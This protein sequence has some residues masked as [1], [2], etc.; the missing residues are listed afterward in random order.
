MAR[1][2]PMPCRCPRGKMPHAQTGSL[3]DSL[4][5]GDPAAAANVAAAIATWALEAPG[6]LNEALVGKLG[7][8]TVLNDPVGALHRVCAKTRQEDR[9]V[10]G[11][12]FHLWVITHLSCDEAGAVALAAFDT[13]PED[14][15]VDP[16]IHGTMLEYPSR[17]LLLV[18]L[19]HGQ[20]LCET[21]IVCAVDDKA[22]LVT[23]WLAW[24][25]WIA[26]G[27]CRVVRVV[28]ARHETVLSEIVE[29][30]LVPAYAVNQ[31]LFAEIAQPMPTMNRVLPFSC[32][33]TPEGAAVAVGT[34]IFGWR[35]RSFIL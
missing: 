34:L 15:T 19:R 22:F 26:V 7:G 12:A 9:V 16:R 3:R 32:S 33:D 5:H 25:G 13:Q 24:N 28:L 17:E 21:P 2:Q 29:L 11:F 10:D 18:P 14:V 4:V 6:H 23:T 35:D 20:C 8:P 30:V 27:S 31:L 1:G